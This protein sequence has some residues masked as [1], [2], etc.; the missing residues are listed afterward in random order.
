MP[1]VTMAISEGHSGKIVTVSTVGN[2]YVKFDQHK[3]RTFN[4]KI[5]EFV[6]AK[7]FNVTNL[8]PIL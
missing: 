5:Y 7:I 3:N 2:V 1:L 6:Q 4:L 8:L